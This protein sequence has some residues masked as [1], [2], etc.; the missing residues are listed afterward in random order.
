MGAHYSK[1]NYDVVVG[2]ATLLT[3]IDDYS[4]FTGFDE[5]WLFA[6]PPL[7]SKPET[8]RITSD[9]PLEQ[10]PPDA[11]IAWMREADCLA[12]LGDGDGLNFVTFDLT[13]A[14]LWREGR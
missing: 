11:L 5:I 10:R 14:E 9:A 4:F 1:V 12:G 8:I 13:L 6:D 7:L 2:G 3:L